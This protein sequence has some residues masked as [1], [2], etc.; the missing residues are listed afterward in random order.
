MQEAPRSNRGWARN[1]LLFFSPFARRRT[2]TFWPGIERSQYLNT[3]LHFSALQYRLEL[4][5]RAAPVQ[6]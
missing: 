3:T 4:W 5:V 1:V 2:S 6:F